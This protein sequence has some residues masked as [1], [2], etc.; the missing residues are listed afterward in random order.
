MLK[1]IGGNVAPSRRKSGLRLDSD[2]TEDA[3]GL[4]LESF[5]TLLSFPRQRF[6]VEPFSR[7]RERWLG[8]DARLEGNQIIGFRPFYMQFKRPQGYPDYSGSS[9]ITQRKTLSLPVSPATLFFP[10]RE[11]QPNHSQFQHNI[12]F[13]LRRRLKARNLGDAAYVCPLFLNRASYRFSLRMSGLWLWP[14]FWRDSPWDLANVLINNSTEEMRFQ[15]VPTLAEHISIPPHA[16]VST[17]KHRY[18]FSEQGRHLCFHSPSSLP[19][20]A[21]T[22]ADFLNEIATGFFGESGIIRIED[23]NDTLKQLNDTDD[24]NP[25]ARAS[26]LPDFVI[27]RDGDPIENWQAWGDELYKTYE[28]AQ[29]AFVKWRSETALYH[30]RI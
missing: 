17:A 4:A 5:L 25:Q 12:L 15:S 30:A 22:L 9:I 14:R 3:V 26:L 7:S 13:R 18:S 6:S 11:K 21:Q 27:P 10:L 24:E 29:F 19:T 23:A 1:H 2:F 8:A 20:G 28:I 16:E